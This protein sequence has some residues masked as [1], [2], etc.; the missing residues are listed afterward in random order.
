MPWSQYLC[1]RN[2]STA[3]TYYTKI[4]H[5]STSDRL[6]FIVTR[7]RYKHIALLALHSSL[8]LYQINTSLLGSKSLIRL[9]KPLP[10][11]QKCLNTSLKDYLQINFF[12][13][14]MVVE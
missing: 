3:S 8:F 9:S 12:L 6:S 7:H 4:L 10:I 11:K 14:L 1:L 5:A 13:D 2:L